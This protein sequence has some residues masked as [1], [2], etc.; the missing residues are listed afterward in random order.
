VNVNAIS[1]AFGSGTVLNSTIAWNFG[2][3]GSAYNTLVGFNAAHEYAKAGTYTITLTVTTP[4]GHVGIATQ[5]VTISQDNR[6]TIYVSPNGNDSNNGSSPS[7]AI[8]SITRL[9]QLLKSNVRVLFQDG[10]TYT[11]GTTPV[12]LGGLQH[13]YVGS[14]GSGAQPVLMYNGP[15]TQGMFIGATSATEGMVVQGLTFNSIYANNKDK[16]AIPSV[17]NMTG[18]DIAVLDNTFLNVLNDIV[19]SPQ[20]PSNVLVQGNSSPD[21][22]ALSAYFYFVGGN[23]IAV[24]G[25]TV[26]NSVGEAVLRV[27]GAND[28]LIADNNFTEVPQNGGTTGGKNVLSIQEGTYAYIYNNTLN[29]GPVEVGPIGTPSADPNGIFKYAVYDSNVL[30]NGANFVINPNAQDVMDKNNVVIGNGN[31]GFTINAQE[32]AGNFNW[33]VQNVFIENNT[34]TDP[35]GQWGGFLSINDGEAAGIHVDNNLFVDPGF[36]IGSGAFIK[37]DNS[38]MKSFAEIKDNVWSLPA[39]VSSFAQGGYFFVSSN[40]SSQ[41]GWLTPAEWEATGIPTGDVYQ[42]V[43]LGATYSVKVDGFTAGSNLPTS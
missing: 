15:A 20:A 17:F 4:D 26:A 39:S 16:Q 23:D 22:T 33:Q 11:L 7:A 32:V 21:P 13:V 2:D 1:S 27:G 8:Q 18:N 34:V 24:I 12:N 36:E 30:I 42:N 10:G 5:Q 29:T 25:N 19:A 31:T 28:I 14:Y 9:N 40:P 6:P 35:A 37:D 43:N 41:S 38:D 3:A